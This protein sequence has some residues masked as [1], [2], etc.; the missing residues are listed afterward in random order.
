MQRVAV[1]NEPRSYLITIAVTANDPAHAASLANAVAFEYLRGQLLQQLTDSYAAVEREVNELSSVYGVRHPSYLSGRTKLE[2]LQEGL[3][4]LREGAPNESL[5]KLVVG[6][7]LL[8]AKAVMVPSGPNL[9]LFLGLT[10]GVA[11]MAGA[12]LAWL[13]E[14]GFIRWGRSGDSAVCTDAIAPG[15]VGGGADHSRVPV[16]PAIGRD[17][18]MG[19]NGKFLDQTASFEQGLERRNDGRT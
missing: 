14:R 7:S 19:A 16:V 5:V 2:R 15:N 18:P 3:R 1:T 9:L 6:Q 12:W 10:G 8:P 13:L 4:D 11:L 17:R